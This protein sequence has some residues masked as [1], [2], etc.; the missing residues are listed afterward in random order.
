MRRLRARLR[1]LSEAEAYHRCHGSR[2]AEVRIVHLEPRRKR[3][4]LRITGEDLRSAFERRL[5]LREPEHPEAAAAP[6]PAEAEDA[7]GAKMAP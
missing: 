6:E 7:V 4:Q 5:D 2:D 3:Y 1:P